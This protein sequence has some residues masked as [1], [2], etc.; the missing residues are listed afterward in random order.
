[1][2]RLLFLTA[3]LLL[4]AVSAQAAREPARNEYITRIESC[5]AI[6]REFMARPETALP[7]E[8]LQRARAIVITN[9]FRAAFIFGVKD[10][11]GVILA[12]RPDGTWSLP[13]LLHAGE[14]SLG[15]QLGGNAVETV[16]VLTDEQTPRLLFEGRFNIGVDAKAVAGPRAAEKEKMNQEILSTP[17]IVYA[18]SKGLFAGASVKAGWIQRDD[19]GNRAFYRTEWGLPEIIYSDWVSAPPEVQP[20]RDYVTQITR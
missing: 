18:R 10:G 20:L 15:L 8:V 1:M 3:A 12:R 7:P 17:V 2:K 4:G 13:A 16:Y 9:Q 5:E 19:N 11:Y 6:L 14:A